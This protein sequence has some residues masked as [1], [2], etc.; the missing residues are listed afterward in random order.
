MRS[1]AVETPLDGARTWLEFPDPAGPVALAGGDGSDGAVQAFR[2][3]ITWLT[4]SWTCVFGRGCQGIY[5]DRPDD[6]CCTLGAHFSDTDDEERVAAAAGQLTRGIWQYHE[7]GRTGG[8]V[9]TEEDGTRKTRVVDGA[10]V[11]LNR[12]GFAPGAFADGAGCALH[13]LAQLEGVEPMETK[14][15][16]CWQLPVRRH[17]ETV[18][19]PDGTSYL[20]V[21]ISEY[22]RR[23]WGPGGHDLD[24][25]CTGNPEAHVASEPVFRALRPEV[26]ELIGEDAYDLLAEYCEQVLAARRVLPLAVHPATDEA[27]EYR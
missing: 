1:S 21:T 27:E 20:L 23:G 7:A 15:D 9:D 12:P 14:P 24:W 17:Y 2:C 10:C 22:D 3:D 11:F 4:S 8:W 19:R 26:T 25:Y 18:E 5:A 6:G 16:V 13:V